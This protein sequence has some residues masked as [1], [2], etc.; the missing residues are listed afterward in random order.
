MKKLCAWCGK[1][2]GEIEPYDNKEI[3]H[4]ICRECKDKE[5]DKLFKHR[6][7]EL[8]AQ[9]FSYYDSYS[10]EEQAKRV[11]KHLEESGDKAKILRKFSSNEFIVYHK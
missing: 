8:K 3:T 2:L 6:E 10:T 11:I 5:Y 7:S 9:G 1:E 4:G